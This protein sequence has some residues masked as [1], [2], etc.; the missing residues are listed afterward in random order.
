MYDAVRAQVGIITSQVT[1]GIMRQGEGQTRGREL[2][3]GIHTALPE[4]DFSSFKVPILAATL[5][6]ANAAYHVEVDE[7]E[8]LNHPYG[9][10]RKNP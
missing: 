8:H 9:R 10:R 4:I 3:L 1:G 7:L 2:T 5:V 6:D